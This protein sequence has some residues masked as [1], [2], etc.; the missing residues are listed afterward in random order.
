LVAGGEGGG[1]SAE[2]R[3]KMSLARKGKRKSEEHRKKLSLALLGNTRML[4][5]KQS[6]EHIAKRI[7]VGWSH[8]EEAKKKVSLARKGHVVPSELRAQISASMKLA[9]A[10]RPNWST[11]KKSQES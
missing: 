4:G 7:R 11:R 8:S 1:V 6:A 10:M 5:K 9:R 3:R 2:S